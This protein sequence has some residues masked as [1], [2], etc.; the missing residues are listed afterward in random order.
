MAITTGASPPSRLIAI[1][2]SAGGIPALAAILRDLPAEFPAAI[3]ITQHRGRHK[4]GML[5]RIL[6]RHS[7]LPVRNA[8]PDEPLEAGTVYLAPPD[9]HLVVE[10]SQLRLD[11][12][13][14]VYFSR[15]SIDV[16]FRSVAASWGARAIGVMLTGAGRDGAEALRAIREADGTV[17]VQDP[18]DAR[19]AML[20]E[21]A[22]AANHIHFTPT[23]D[24]IG[25]LLVRLVNSEVG[26]GRLR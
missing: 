3:V 5:A 15:P 23:L 10:T 14:P 4:D 8:A 9:R 12:G 26:I 18:R 2:V 17:I 24:A 11:A 1:G 22:I 19:Y 25:P 16:M 21:S 20:P 13:P 6:A 7:K